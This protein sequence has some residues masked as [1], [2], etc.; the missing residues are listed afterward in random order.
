MITDGRW[1]KW[2]LPFFEWHTVCRGYTQ[3]WLGF[4]AVYVPSGMVHGATGS[5]SSLQ[6]L[7]RF[8]DHGW[9]WMIMDIC[10]TLVILCDFRIFSTWNVSRLRSCIQDVFF[11][12]WKSH[13]ISIAFL[14]CVL[15]VKS[16]AVVCAQENHLMNPLVKALF[17]LK[18][19]NIQMWAT[20][21]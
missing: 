5:L 16:P 14:V 9:S 1:W 6:E 10:R 11:L 8:I 3:P 12:A 21:H 7:C 19:R 2:M 4:S 20:Y 17:S 13:G 15:E 18:H